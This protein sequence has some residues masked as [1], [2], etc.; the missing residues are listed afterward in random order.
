[1]QKSRFR[2]RASTAQT[3]ISR[4]ANKVDT[5]NSKDADHVCATSSTEELSSRPDPAAQFNP[6]LFSWIDCYRRLWVDPFG[7]EWS[8]HWASTTRSRIATPSI[9]P[10]LSV[11]LLPK[12]FSKTTRF[13]IWATQT[14]AL[15]LE[16]LES[17]VP[18]FSC[19]G[20]SLPPIHWKFHSF[21]LVQDFID[22]N[23]KNFFKIDPCPFFVAVHELDFVTE[24]A[25]NV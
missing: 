19:F 8:H 10:H 15:E 2:E 1:M 6:G 7:D 24:L 12:K 23:K 22:E 13:W 14:R 25:L 18:S 17:P 5:S 3:S 16:A 9:L 4:P 21:L 20:V 11:D